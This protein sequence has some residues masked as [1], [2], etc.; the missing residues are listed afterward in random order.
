MTTTEECMKEMEKRIEA[1]NRYFVEKSPL[2][3]TVEVLS[4]E[5][6]EALM[7]WFYAEDEGPMKGAKILDIS[8]EEEIVTKREALAVRMIREGD[9]FVDV[10][11]E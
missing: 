5:A 3:L 6:V 4:S 9:Q 7:H 11:H 10:D 8:W 1:T 2:L